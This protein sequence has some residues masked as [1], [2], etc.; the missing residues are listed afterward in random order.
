MVCAWKRV[1]NKPGRYCPSG[2]ADARSE[3]IPE[4]ER[5]RS[6][7]RNET[8]C[9]IIVKYVQWSMHASFYEINSYFSQHLHIFFFIIL[10]FRYLEIFQ[11]DML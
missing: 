4:S 11:L 3:T 5:E 7:G 2:I 6:C 10:I 1:Q 9:M 8:K